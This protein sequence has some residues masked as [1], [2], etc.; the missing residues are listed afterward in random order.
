MAPLQ[1]LVPKKYNHLLLPAAAL[2]ALL[3]TDMT[4]ADD[5]AVLD[6]GSLPEASD[7]NTYQ[8]SFFDQY[9]PQNALDMIRRLPGFS[10]DQGSQARGFGGNA[11]NVLI[12][13]SRP[14]S[15]SGGI[16]EALE[17]IPA[18]QVERIEIL[19]GGI[20][21]SDAGGQSVVAN[22]IR[23]SSGTSGTWLLRGR[24][25]SDGRVLP[26]FEG[27]LASKFSGWDTSSKIDV[28]WNGLKRIAVLRDLDSTLNLTSSSNEDFQAEWNYQVFSTEASRDFAGG[29][30]TL[31]TRFLH[32]G[33][34]DDFVRDGFDNRLPDNGTPDDR[35]RLR[36]QGEFYEF[37]FGTDWKRTF[38]NDWKLNTI[39]LGVYKKRTFVS[40]DETEE[41]LGT[42][43]E[44]SQFNQDFNRKE[45]IFRTTYGDVGKS[46]FKPEFGFETARNS[47]DNRS[48]FVENDIEQELSNPNIKVT[49]LRGEAFATFVYAATSKLS[50]DGGITGEVSQ[51]EL[52]G[53]SAN[54]RTFKFLKPRITTTYN[55]SDKIQLQTQF[56]RTVGQ[57]NFRDFAADTNVSDG[58]STAGNS[59]LAPNTAW[60]LSS[61]FDWKFSDRG[62]LKVKAFHEWRQDVLE[63][64]IIPNPDDPDDISFGLGNAGSAT[65]YGVEADLNLPIDF[66]LPNALFEIE[67]N[68]IDS[69]FTDPITGE[70]RR[71]S[72][73]TPSWLGFNFRHDITSAKVSWGLRYMGSFARQTFNPD[74]IVTFSGNKRLNAFIETTRWFGLRM[75]ARV[76]FLNSGKFT[77]Q[78]DLFDTDNNF[79]FNGSEISDRIR[80]PKIFFEISGT[81]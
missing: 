13:G 24:R 51:I 9:N 5:A 70:N 75:K 43:S 20:S 38:S 58:R 19:R 72:N 48:S 53:D 46:K 78:R 41:E 2:S 14:T 80:R 57:L 11:G 64:I 47:L 81:F 74:Q 36:A 35:W 8:V 16:R 50:I 31:N 27:T 77:R 67:F 4:H 62:S 15:K 7:V 34:V 69:S 39:L 40:R 44:T 73:F 30:L 42:I 65:F 52:S 21:A 61:T 37:E 18:A 29:K 66:I 25:I 71:I 45:F 10:F 23:K 68:Q 59:D 54:K 32:D 49:E 79:S 6:D 3:I 12:D 22:V 33:F 26:S 55:F 28:G 1:W 60:E 76:E 63:Q 17:R 56:E